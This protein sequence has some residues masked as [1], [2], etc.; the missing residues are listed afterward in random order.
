MPTHAAPNVGLRPRSRTGHEGGATSMLGRCRGRKNGPFE[1]QART[2]VCLARGLGAITGRAVNRVREP[3]ATPIAG[4]G[5]LM[6][7]MNGPVA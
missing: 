7:R 5:Q 3:E 6:M 4:R 1:C 2:A